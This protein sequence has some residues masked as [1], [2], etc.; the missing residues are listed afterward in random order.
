MDSFPSILPKAVLGNDII[1]FEAFQLERFDKALEHG[2]LSIDAMCWL[3]FHTCC[4]FD[5]CNI[6]IILNVKMQFNQLFYDQ[7]ILHSF[8]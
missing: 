8:L 2:V 6:S 1:T 4:F 7:Q 5:S 3:C